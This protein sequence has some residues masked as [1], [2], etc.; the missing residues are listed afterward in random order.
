[1]PPAIRLPEPHRERSIVASLIFAWAAR[2]GRSTLEIALRRT[3]SP[4]MPERLRIRQLYEFLADQLL[5]A[6]ERELIRVDRTISVPEFLEEALASTGA[7]L[8][9]N[10]AADAPIVRR[11]MTEAFDRVRVRTFE[12]YASN[13][14]PLEEIGLW[15]AGAAAAAHSAFGVDLT[16]RLDSIEIRFAAAAGPEPRG[17][18][19]PARLV[20]EALFPDD[21]GPVSSVG[22]T[23]GARPDE[24]T[25]TC[26]PYVLLHEL[27]SHAAQGPWD[28]TC[29]APSD[30]D[31]FAEGWMDVAA[32]AVHDLSVAGLGLAKL[33]PLE[34][35]SA[36]VQ[37]A[38]ARHQARRNQK[39]GELIVRHLGTTIASQVRAG[40]DAVFGGPGGTEQFLAFSLGLNVSPAGHNVRRQFVWAANQAWSG[41]RRR[42]ELIDRLASLDALSNPDAVA[43]EIAAQAED[44]V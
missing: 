36:Y 17:A 9:T 7:V 35:S 13:Q 32:L 10:L 4:D 24:A 19:L 25:W 15:C 16:A 3:P 5:A 1:M 22:V 42:T 28:A 11:V 38:A 14:S 43:E 40:L 26:V 34:D 6:A 33:D 20:G 44:A 2:D 12:L 21:G 41:Q 18:I 23:I 30:S 37:A 27:V 29:L 39:H 31:E 8:G